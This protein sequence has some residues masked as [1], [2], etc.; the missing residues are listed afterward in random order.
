VEEAELVKRQRIGRRQVV[1]GERMVRLRK[2]GL[3]L[4]VESWTSC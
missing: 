2:S 3:G 4:L 1:P